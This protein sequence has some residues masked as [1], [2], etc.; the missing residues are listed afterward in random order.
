MM[1]EKLVIPKQYWFLAC[2]AVYKHE[3]IDGKQLPK[4]KKQ[5]S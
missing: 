5:M 4:A 1:R 3:C 2:D